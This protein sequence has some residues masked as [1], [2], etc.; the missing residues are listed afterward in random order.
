[1][2]SSISDIAN[3]LSVTPPALKLE[4]KPGPTCRPIMKTNSISPKSC[5]KVRV[6]I[7]A[8]NPICPATMPAK[9]TKVTPRDMPPIFSLPR[10]TPT[11]ITM[12]YSSAICGILSLFVNKL[13][14]QS[15]LIFSVF[16]IL[17]AKL[18]NFSD[19]HK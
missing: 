4:K 19:T 12:A 17:N 5:I 18:L 14:N 10:Y 13:N 16:S 8:V 9:S 11:A 6:A 7:G 3:T 1:M 15:I 2:F